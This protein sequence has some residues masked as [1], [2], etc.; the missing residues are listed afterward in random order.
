MPF[1]D[2]GLLF[3]T[4]LILSLL[5][6]PVSIRFAHFIGAIDHPSDRSV[7]ATGM[8]RLGGLGMALAI[9][10]GLPLFVEINQIFLG[11]LS[12][13]LIIIIIGCI[14]DIW[15]TRPLI[16]MLGQIAACIVFM[17][18][19]G[20]SFS[21]LGNLFALGELSFSAPVN[22]AMTLFCMVGLINAFNF[23]DG[24][25]GLAAGSV[26]IACFFLGLLA[27]VAQNWVGLAVIVA[28]IGGVLGF[29]KFNSY[30]AKL[31]MGDTGSLMLGFSIG[32]LSVILA[33]GGS[34]SIQPV[35]LSII[36]GIPIVDTVC[37]M[38][39]R[40]LQGKS[41]MY[42]DKTHLHHRLL[43]LGLPHALV[44]AVLYALMVI[45]GALA[46][47]VQ[48]Y[49]A[50]WQSA[51]GVSLAVL[52]YVLLTV[53]EYK[54]VLVHI[55]VT[56]MRDER[57]IR[58]DMKSLF[59]QSMRMVPAVILFGLSVPLLMAQT[60]PSE[61]GTLAVYL[62]VLVI[63]AFPWKE[64]HDNLPVVYGLF[65]L[66]AFDILYTWNVSSYG[67][68]RPDIYEALFVAILCLWI[69]LKITF[70]RNN[71]VFLTSN[72]ELLL[73]FISWFIPYI[74]LPAAGVAEHVLNAAKFTCIGA[75]PL[76]LA[77]KLVIRR[78][79]HRN[80]KMM[81]GLIITLGFIALRAM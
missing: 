12:G 40:V 3:F 75:I 2:L 53:C 65:Y 32:S 51:A 67:A 61:M 39:C 43:A 5:I 79:P 8:P 71:E 49:P 52:M 21:T 54:N 48:A 22:Y 46:L 4:V 69:A 14:D 57:E 29:L 56:M 45:F 64:H 31:F 38:T 26:A 25:D 17:E 1:E 60:I 20:L 11:F 59:G 35:T 73:I 80:R 74:I 81:I 28:L 78:Q 36:L 50:Y 24:L 47:T 9:L 27:L 15:Q 76:F 16:K 10:L 68:F 13:L 62:A 7:H 19:S 42:P 44:V 77:L 18:I 30:P 37:V 55:S 41:P 72:F 34:G 33:D 23:S 66:C 63:I 58:Y 70:K 6:T